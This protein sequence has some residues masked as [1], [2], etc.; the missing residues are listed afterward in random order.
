MYWSNTDVWKT[1]KEHK[2]LMQKDVDHN[3]EDKVGFSGEGRPM[4]ARLGCVG[5]VDRCR[6]EVDIDLQKLPTV[7]KE[8]FRQFITLVWNI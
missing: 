1:P 3:L 4:C 7:S 2:N 6:R 8:L 5:K